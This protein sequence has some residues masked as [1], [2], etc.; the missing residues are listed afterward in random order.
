MYESTNTSSKLGHGRA[1]GDKKEKISKRARRCN[2]EKLTMVVVQSGAQRM[3][4]KENVERPK[5]RK[6]GFK[7]E[8]AG[9]VL[10]FGKPRG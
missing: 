2:A 4:D 3:A 6:R 10:S 8:G 9:G 7:V 1:S 5:R